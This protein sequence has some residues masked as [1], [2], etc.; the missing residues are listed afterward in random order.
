MKI[1]VINHTLFF[2]WIRHFVDIFR[3]RASKF[4]FSKKLI[5]SLKLPKFS[6]KNTVKINGLSRHKET[7]FL[8][9]KK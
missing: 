6:G 8:N 9:Q 7:K 3:R 4:L 2:M 1:K 5:K